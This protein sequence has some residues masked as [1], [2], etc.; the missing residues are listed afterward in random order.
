MRFL[1]DHPIIYLLVLLGVF[2]S[3]TRLGAA[4]RSW[5]GPLDETKRGDFDIVLGATLTLL[6]LIVGFSFSMAASRYDQRKNLEEE[7]A[8]AIGTAYARADF[9]GAD[10][11]SVKALLREYTGLR[12]QFY[13]IND[14]SKRRELLAETNRMQDRL[15][16]AVV[17]P[18]TANPNALTAIAATSMNDAINS[19]G[20]AQAAKWNRIPLGAWVLL[21]AIGLVATTMIGF[22]FQAHARQRMLMLII[23]ALIS[24]SMGLIA[25]IDCPLGGVIL[26]GPQ[27]LTALAAT[28]H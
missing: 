22:R 28:L 27:N 21:C 17:V 3:S 1:L 14:T 15:W 10:T 11:A 20:Y 24:I 2:W 5:L 18:A 6:S 13:T 8:N 26:I 9:I 16:S 12:I 4:V 7:E 19:Q 25:D 23:P